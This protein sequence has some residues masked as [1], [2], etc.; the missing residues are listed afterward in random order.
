M[1]LQRHALRVTAALLVGVLACCSPV[2]RSGRVQPGA[3]PRRGGS[4]CTIN[5]T[6]RDDVLA[7]TAAADTICG[8]GGNDVLVGR[9]GRDV[10]IGGVGSDA[11]FGG[12]QGDKIRGD[13]GI[14]LL[15]GGGGVDVLRGGIGDDRCTLGSGDRA[16][17]CSP[18]PDAPVVAAAGDIACSPDDDPS[19]DS[20]QQGSTSDLLVQGDAWAVLT[21]GDDQYEDGELQAF[22]GSYAAS[23]G[24]VKAI[25]RPSPGNHDYHVP[26][27]AGYYAYF[28][29]VAGDPDKGYYSFDVGAWHLIA[30]NSNCDAVGCDT[31]SPQVEWLTA[32]SGGA[33]VH[34]HAR[35]LAPPALLL[36]RTWR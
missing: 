18:S 10:L 17:S 5:G 34:L 9:G 31:G 16:L 21:L 8:F 32:R 7:G 33:R 28:G 4:T 11:V 36:R 12:G 15:L 24:R 13:A 20:C 3:S 29:P 6:A 30:L 19:G 2:D 14:D 22:Q 27:G 23:W 1:N 35:L 25:T 26:G